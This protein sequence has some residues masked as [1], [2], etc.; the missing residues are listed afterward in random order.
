MQCAIQMGG[1]I[2]I[3]NPKTFTDVVETFLKGKPHEYRAFQTK[4]EAYEWLKT[5]TKA[6]DARHN[7]NYEKHGKK[8]ANAGTATSGMVGGV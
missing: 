6:T 4:E 5:R 7:A 8:S 1:G 3:C 2:V